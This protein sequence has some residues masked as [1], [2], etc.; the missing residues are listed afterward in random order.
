MTKPPRTPADVLREARAKDSRDKRAKVIAAVDAMVAKGDPVTFAAVAKAARVSNWLVYAEGVREHIEAARAKQGT[1]KA[2]ATKA[3][4]TASAA[5]LATD[6]ELARAEVRKLRDERDRLRDA[7]RRKLGDQIDQAASQ[8]LIARNG[9]LTAQNQELAR[10]LDELRRIANK[11]AR[12]IEELEDD[13]AASR[14]AHRDLMR[15]AN[16][17]GQ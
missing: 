17:Q 16:R 7:M 3:G 4:A 11:Q 10:E 6:L 13:L 12:R 1:A 5:S 8:D 2:R 15:E 9:E 14:Q